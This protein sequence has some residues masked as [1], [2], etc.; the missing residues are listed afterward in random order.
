MLRC[1][2]CAFVALVIL[3]TKSALAATIDF[4]TLQHIIDHGNSITLGDKQF[5]DFVLT[6]SSFA[7]PGAT[8]TAPTASQI[9]VQGEISGDFYKIT[10]TNFTLQA[11]TTAAGQRAQ[12]DLT[13]MFDVA[14]TDPLRGIDKVALD[15]TAVN[16]GLGHSLLDES[17]IGPTSTAAL[18]AN[19][20]TPSVNTA[21]AQTRTLHIIKDANV[22]AVGRSAT[23]AAN[24][25][26]TE[27]SQ[28]FHQF[29]PHHP[30]PP[31]PEPASI[32]MWTLVAF[33]SGMAIRRGQTTRA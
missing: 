7:S 3:C 27:I 31:V 6:R 12:A 19:E 23:P 16:T 28:T 24:A 11:A 30:P 2:H 10:F 33:V 14:V 15:I 22:L 25:T 18:H 9:E 26:I 13:I 21:V 1:F 20:T 4:G 5:S 8:A 32:V 29:G 17:I